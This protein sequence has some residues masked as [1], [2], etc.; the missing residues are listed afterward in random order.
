MDALP[1]EVAVKIEDEGFDRGRALRQRWVAALV[2]YAGKRAAVRERQQRGVDAVLLRQDA[3]RVRRD[4]GSGKTQRAADVLAAFDDAAD[5]HGNT[6][7]T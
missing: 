3:A 2:E 7:V 4:V 5:A 1:V 6:S